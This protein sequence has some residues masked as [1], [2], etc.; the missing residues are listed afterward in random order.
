MEYTTVRLPNLCRGRV[1]VICTISSSGI[2][3]SRYYHDGV[4]QFALSPRVLGCVSGSDIELVINR[5][6]IVF[7]RFNC[8]LAPSAYDPNRPKTNLVDHRLYTSPSARGATEV[9]HPSWT[10]R[11]VIDTSTVGP[12]RW[13]SKRRECGGRWASDSSCFV[14]D[15][16]NRKVVS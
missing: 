2:A 8:S 12:S 13:V 7:Q 6:R 3:P 16:N 14:E 5:R 10:R 1:W 15:Q 11:S 9:V 4:D